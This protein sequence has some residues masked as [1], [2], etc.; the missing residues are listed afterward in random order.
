MIELILIALVGVV[1]YFL[2][3]LDE[4]TFRFKNHEPRTFEKPRNGRKR[5]TK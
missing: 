2:R 3:S 4:V 1:L 5:L